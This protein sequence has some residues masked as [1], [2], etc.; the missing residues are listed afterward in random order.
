MTCEILDVTMSTTSVVI[1]SF[2]WY[3]ISLGLTP[4]YDTMV[5]TSINLY[6]SISKINIERRVSIFMLTSK[7]CRFYINWSDSCC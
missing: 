2:A 7:K 1:K 3:L 6:C 4:A 5:L